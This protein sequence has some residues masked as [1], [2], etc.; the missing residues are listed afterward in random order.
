MQGQIVGVVV[1]GEAAFGTRSAARWRMGGSLLQQFGDSKDDN[2]SDD[3]KTHHPSNYRVE[4]EITRTPQGWAQYIC[5]A[6]GVN[7]GRL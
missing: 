2:T 3:H 4:Y 6:N 1:V 7:H 5:K